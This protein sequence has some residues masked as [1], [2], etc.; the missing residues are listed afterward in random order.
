MSVD[1]RIKNAL[2]VFGYDISNSVSYAKEDTYFSF[3][4]TVIPADFGDDAPCH[5]RNLVTVN[6][7]C[8]LNV[9]I[10]SLKQRIRQRLYAAGFTWA[11]IADASDGNGRHTVFEC[12]DAE[13]VDVN[14]DDANLGV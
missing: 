8:P 3:S 4:Y 10:T 13:G 11:T 2:S 14:G 12:E 6:L 9:N 5:E 1:A 7:F